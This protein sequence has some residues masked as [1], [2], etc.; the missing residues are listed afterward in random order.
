[1]HKKV[2]ERSDIQKHDGGMCR[3]C[4]RSVEFVIKN[5]EKNQTAK[6]KNQGRHGFCIYNTNYIH[7]L[8]QRTSVIWRMLRPDPPDPNPP[9]TSG[10]CSGPANPL[11][12]V[13]F[14]SSVKLSPFRELTK[15][16][17]FALQ[18]SFSVS[19]E[20]LIVLNSK[21]EVLLFVFLC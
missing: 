7:S 20:R 12:K 16:R 3:K 11:A 21:T 6:P 13:S 19:L 15:Y 17:K 14:V 4:F 18:S 10:T 2:T 1:M 5:D 8:S 9:D